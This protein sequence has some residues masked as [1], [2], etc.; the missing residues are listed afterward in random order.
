MD[1]DEDW[2]DRHDLDIITL[3][4]RE[5]ELNEKMIN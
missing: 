5:Q 2:Y 3:T 4:N 1:E